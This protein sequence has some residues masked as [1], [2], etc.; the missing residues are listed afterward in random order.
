MVAG[1]LLVRRVRSARH[2]V[3]RTLHVL[4]S[5]GMRAELAE[6]RRIRE[7]IARDPELLAFAAGRREKLPDFYRENLRRRL[8]RYAELLSE[9]DLRPELEAAGAAD[10]PR[11]ARAVPPS[12]PS[13]LPLAPIQEAAL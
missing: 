2:P 1:A 13:L 9:A 6:L 5:L 7:R 11:R 12:R 4:R 8:G 10:P 3:L